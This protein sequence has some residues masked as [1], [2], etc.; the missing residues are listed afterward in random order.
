M[1]AAGCAGMRGGW[2]QRLVAYA[3]GG[4]LAVLSLWALALTYG[5]PSYM[6]L[7]LAGALL[8]MPSGL[9][10]AHYMEAEAGEA[11]AGEAETREAQPKGEESCD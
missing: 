4:T 11:E 1:A 9:I 10:F 6:D 8:V 3:F 5:R 7:A 2:P